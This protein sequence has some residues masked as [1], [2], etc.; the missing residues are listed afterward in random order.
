MSYLSEYCFSSHSQ[1][2][3]VILNKR[4][5]RTRQDVSPVPNMLPVQPR[6]LLGI[7]QFSSNGNQHDL[8]L[9]E[10]GTS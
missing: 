5:V 10:K 4:E 6:E 1:P 7:P 8:Q 2:P 9:K 3:S